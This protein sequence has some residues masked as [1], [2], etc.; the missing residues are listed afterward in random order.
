MKT[1]DKTFTL[2]FLH[3]EWAGGGGGGG[4]A[5]TLHIVLGFPLLQ[6][7]SCHFVKVGNS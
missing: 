2:Y 1:W 7:A 4:E 6:A 5:P 3:S